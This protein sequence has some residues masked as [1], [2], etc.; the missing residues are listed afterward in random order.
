MKKVFL[1]LILG[2][3]LVSLTSATSIGTFEQNQDVELYQTCN[4][5]SYCNFT[6]I[7][8]PNSSEIV[9]DVE[10]IQRGT[11][12]YYDLDGGNTSV[13]GTYVYCYDCGNDVEKD[14]GCINFIITGNGKE[15]PDG[16]VIVVFSIFFLLLLIYLIFFLFEGIGHFKNL[17]FDI[18]DLSYNWGGYFALFGLYML[19][20]TY[21]GNPDI[22]GFLIMFIEIGALTNFLLPLI[23]FIVSYFKQNTMKGDHN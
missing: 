7:K 4:N 6:T 13:L 19:E 22:E 15:N 23:A 20:K 12:Y 11:Y 21:L 2:M 8:Y 5:C 18:R 9:T 3:F 17:D 16:V 10:T 14:T 1:T